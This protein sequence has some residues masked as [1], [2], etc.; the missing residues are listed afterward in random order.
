MRP[1]RPGDLYPVWWWTPPAN[2]ARI[3][4]IQPYR[5]RYPEYFSHVLRL[6]SDTK[7]GWLD[8]AVLLDDTITSG[9][10]PIRI[11]QVPA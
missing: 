10:Q 4:E 6:F 9:R 3:I 5:G 7:Q 2:M 11:E 8:M 1:L